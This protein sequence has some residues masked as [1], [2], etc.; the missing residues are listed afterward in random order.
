MLAKHP[1]RC[2]FPHGHSRTIEVVVEAQT[3]DARDMV[4]DFK[5][6]K[7]ALGSALHAWDHALAMNT[8]DPHFAQWSA[9]YGAQIIPFDKEDPTTEVMAR[10]I[11]YEARKRLADYAAQPDPQYPMA[12]GVKLVKVRVWE[13]R[14]AW[15]E[16]TEEEES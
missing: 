16:F 7:S 4:C 9:T 1:D 14:D 2:R 6:L 11:F 8:D 3:L 15:A 13:T 5:A 12:P 10:T